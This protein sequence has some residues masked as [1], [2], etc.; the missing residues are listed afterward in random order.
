VYRNSGGS[1][2]KYDSGSW[3]N[4]QRQSQGQTYQSQTRASSVDRSTYDGLN[5]DASARA[6]GNQRTRDYSNYQRSGGASAGSYRSSGG[7]RSYGGGR[8]G[9][10]RGGG[11]RRR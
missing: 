1:W 3:N 7:G 4:V 9:G 5:R 11:G 8:G 6:S 10:G 2:Q